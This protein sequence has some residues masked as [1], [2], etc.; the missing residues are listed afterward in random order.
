MNLEIGNGG[1][2][3]KLY[4]KYRTL[5]GHV[6]LEA[7]NYVAS[8]KPSNYY[9]KE[10]IFKW[11]IE[12]PYHSPITSESKNHTL[13]FKFKEPFFLE[14]YK[15]FLNSNVRFASKFYVKTS[16]RGSPFATVYYNNETLCSSIA[17]NKDCGAKTIKY[18][19]IPRNNI[20]ICDK[21]QIVLDGTDSWGTY[22]ISFYGLEFFGFYKKNETCKKSQNIH[23]H[24]F[25][26]ITLVS[27]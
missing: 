4:E 13:L 23:Q 21:I 14:G 3:T 6:E 24:F 27:S 10:N 11:N 12:N 16:F 22:S 8:S 15:T 7:E 26:L 2:F 5:E 18:F 20:R 19:S 25:L 1:I 9:V 17:A